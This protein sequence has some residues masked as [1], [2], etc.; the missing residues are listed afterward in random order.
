[1]RK[2]VRELLGRGYNEDQVQDYFVARYGEWI[3]LAP[4]ADGGGGLNWLIWVLPAA[5]GGVALAVVAAVAARWRREPDPVPPASEAGKA[6]LDPYE[7]RLLR[8]IDR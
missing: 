2:R 5:S 7:E 6:P 4:P 8:E 1:M 3:L